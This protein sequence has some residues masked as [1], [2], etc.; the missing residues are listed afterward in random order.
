MTARPRAIGYLRSSAQ[1]DNDVSLDTQR[2]AI[3]AWAEADGYDVVYCDLDDRRSGGLPE[4]KR[5]GLARALATLAAG[6]AA[7]LYAYDWA[8]LSRDNE[9]AARIKRLS[10]EQGWE[11]RPGGTLSEHS[12]AGNVSDAAQALAAQ[13]HRDATSERMLASYA[14]RRAEAAAKGEP[15]R[16]GPPKA[17]PNPDARRMARNL[18]SRGHSLRAIAA[19]LDERGHRTP[20]GH[21]WTAA[22]VQRLIDDR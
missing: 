9:L 1:G 16:F 18:R 10:R 11:L 6:E 22:A 2:R 20:R 17:P 12:M 3:S 14:R 4:D 21:A 13:A 8:R 7:C 5:P 15:T 19:R